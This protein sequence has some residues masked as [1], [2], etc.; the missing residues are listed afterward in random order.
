MIKYIKDLK[1]TTHIYRLNNMKKIETTLIW[2]TE[3]LKKNQIPFQITGGLAARIYGATR[4][5]ADIDID[6]PEDKFDIVKKEV[7]DFII[8]G[9]A[10]FKSDKWDLL[11]MTLKFQ[12][13]LIDLGGAYHTKIF[14]QKT[15]SWQALRE[16]LSQASSQNVFGLQLPVISKNSLIAYKKAL[17]RPED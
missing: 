12:G 4:P 9:P 13:Q 3:I 8:Y 17:S 14:N 10:H 2:I 7:E 5:I 1:K 6:I 16:D 15:K 11:L